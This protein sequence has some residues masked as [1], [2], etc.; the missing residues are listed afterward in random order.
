M[1][2]EDIFKISMN[3][4]EIIADPPFFDALVYI[5]G[6]IVKKLKMHAC[7][8]KNFLLDSKED[9][10]IQ[11]IE[12][13]NRGKLTYPSKKFVN[14]IGICFNIMEE[15]VRDNLHKENLSAAK[16]LEFFMDELE[17]MGIAEDFTCSHTTKLEESLNLF[18]KILINN[19][20]KLVNNKFIEETRQKSYERKMRKFNNQ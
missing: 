5:G 16:I 11:Y 12:S 10:N 3:Y 1:G 14:A 18:V 4:D 9:M 2:L 8:S 13:I 7:C 19:Y 20:S 17:T 6:F 15:Y